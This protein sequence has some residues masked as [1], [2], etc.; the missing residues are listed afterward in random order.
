[1]TEVPCDLA[2]LG[3]G[4]M[5]RNLALNF[6]DHG[7]RVVASDPFAAVVASARAALTPAVEVVETPEATIPR[8][9]RPR[10]LLIMVKAGDP[11]DA[12]LDR[13]A[14]LLAPG[15]VVIDG[16]NSHPSDTERRVT[17]LAAVGAHFVGLGIS[18]GGSGARHGPALMAGGAPGAIAAVRP[19][20]EAIAA[21]AADGAPCF[22]VFGPGGAG[23]FVKTAHNGIEYALMQVFAEI[24]LLLGASGDTPAAAAAVVDGWRAGPAASFLLDATVTALAAV[25]ADTGRPLIEV[26]RDRAGHKGTGR[27]T[28]D[29]ADELGVAVPAIAAAFGARVLSGRRVPDAGP[30]ITA[31]APLPASLAADLGTALPAAMLSAHLQGLALIREAAERHG[32]ATDTA[33]VVRTW[34]AGCIIRAAML[35]PL[36]AALAAEPDPNR[37][38]AT[39]FGRAILADAEAPLRRVVAAAALA[40][41]PVPAFS[42]VLA[43]LDGLRATNVGASIIQATRDLFGAHGFERTDRPGDFHHPWPTES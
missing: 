25:D 29:A 38:L 42:A 22:G 11:I 26:I 23:H 32:W 35:D 28:V 31:L 34:R 33:E 10:R 30:A 1:M 5:G 18:G 8:L 40:G 13:L 19:M 9:G 16:G 7:H 36:A 21:R 14:P 4:V 12:L 3:L 27:W 6:A 43:H 15:D 24:G 17:K 20:L 39:P 37:L 41:V 2:V